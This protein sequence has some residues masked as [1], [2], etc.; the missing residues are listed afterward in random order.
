MFAQ[1]FSA[2]MARLGPEAVPLPRIEHAWQYRAESDAAAALNAEPGNMTL[3]QRLRD[4]EGYRAIQR[5]RRTALE[6]LLAVPPTEATLAKAVDLIAAICE[7]S[8]W[9]ANRSNQ[10][11]DDEGHPEI[12]LQ[13]AETAVLLGWTNRILGESLQQI[14]PRIAPR[15]TAEVRRRAFRPLQVHDD[16]AFMRGEDACPMTVAADLLLA[17]L[18][19]ER[20]ETRASRIL[21]PLLRILDDNCGRHGR[22][23]V[24]LA[25]AVTEIA[26]VTDLAVLIRAATDDAVDLSGAVPAD[27]WL[28]EILFSWI[29]DQYFVD[30]AGDGMKPPLPGSDIF[31][32]G[33]TTGD[34]PLTALGAQVFH[35]NAL[36]SGTVTGRIM[37][38]WAISKLE[39]AVGR[40]PLLR[41]AAIRNNRLMTARIP[42]LY[43]ALHVG[44]GHANAGDF[45]LFADGAPILVD[46]GRDCRARNLPLLCGREQLSMPSH[47]CIADFEDR[48]DREFMSVD[49]TH[50]YPS[51]CG[52]RSFQR[53]VLTLRAER[54]VRL[55][56]ALDFES[57]AGVSFAFVTPVRPA[58]LSTAVRLGPVRMTW[59]GDFDVSASPLSGALYRLELTATQP[60]RQG[61]F[62]F[63][64]E[65]A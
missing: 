50:A 57:P 40:P 52:L 10:P 34:E 63:N 5:A 24:P 18:M 62:A 46:G 8:T 65:G 20:D 28:D 11:F 4:A 55:V 33:L 3:S 48:E 16:Y 27:D 49:L 26:A 30:P 39:T 22:A 56:D 64:F 14:S 51:E 2:L 43:C 6:A 17:C 41:Y 42:G 1:A 25:E 58:V 44:G 35:H 59:E 60:V 45:C 29:Q 13:C 12:D 23:F 7:E 15:M 37:D 54:T 36:P 38:G 21:R 32:I 47:P 19:L 61:L 9:S 31:R 53:T